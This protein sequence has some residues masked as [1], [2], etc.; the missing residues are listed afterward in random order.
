MFDNSGGG[1]GRLPND[2]MRKRMTELI[3][4]IQI[5]AANCGG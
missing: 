2:A 1:I 3:E 4:A 5:A